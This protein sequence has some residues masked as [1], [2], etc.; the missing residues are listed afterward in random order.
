MPDLIPA[1]GSIA[2]SAPRPM[3]FLMV[4][5]V[6]ATRGSPGSVSVV[7]AT[8]IIPPTAA[9]PAQADVGVLRFRLC[10]EIRHPD[11]DHDDNRHRHFYQS[12]EILIG[13]FVSRVIVARRTRVFDLTV[14][15]H[16][17][18][19]NLVPGIGGLSVIAFMEQPAAH[20]RNHVHALPERDRIPTLRATAVT[21]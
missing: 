7:T 19:P 6:A 13:L 9:S 17:S 15:G 18:P 5:G 11:N 12:D 1:P 2:T 8:F 3:I 20:D 4:S 14:I 10:Q 16:R 21:D